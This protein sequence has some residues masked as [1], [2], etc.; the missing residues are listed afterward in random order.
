MFIW[1][2]E[3]LQEIKC[4]KPLKKGGV[5]ENIVALMLVDEG[6]CKE[7]ESVESLEDQLHKGDVMLDKTTYIEVKSSHTWKGIPKLALDWEYFKKGTREP[8]YQGTNESN[9][10]WLREECNYNTLIAFNL[11][12]K[13]MYIIQEWQQVRRNIINIV[14]E[15]LEVNRGIEE[16]FNR[17]VKINMCLEL[18]IVNRDVKKTG[19]VVFL[20]LTRS[21]CLLGGKLIK[22]KFKFKEK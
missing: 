16:F 3:S 14:E 21:I 17:D 19:A 15:Y 20:N 2:G 10:G 5:I 11:D 13:E 7:V 4:Y 12:L 1:N 18:G 8:Y 22:K 6:I 9:V